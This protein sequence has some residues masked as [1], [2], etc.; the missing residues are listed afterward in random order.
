MFN[1]TPTADIIDGT[2]TD[3]YFERTINALNHAEKNPTVIADIT[4]SQFTQDEY[5]ILSGVNNAVKTLAEA[6]DEID[7]WALPEGCAFTGGPVMRIKGPY[8][9]FAKFET[10]ILGFLSHA[11]GIATNAH[12]IVTSAKQESETTV[13]SFGGRAKHPSIAPYIERSALIG[14]VD[15]ISHVS[16]ANELGVDATGT[17]PHALVLAFQS[18]EKAWNAYNESAEENASR[19]VIAD[20]FTDETDEALR[21]AE[22]LGDDLNGIR[23]DTTG[24]RRG[25]F[26]HIIREVK[27]KLKNKGFKDIP[28][29]IS[30][31]LTPNTVEQLAPL[32]SGVGV[33]GYISDADSMDFSLDIVVNE[34]E[35]ITK[36]GKLPG[37]KAPNIEQS[38]HAPEE[39]AGTYTL[40]PTD[41]P[42]AGLF[43]KVVNNGVVLRDFSINKARKTANKTTYQLQ[44]EH[45][46]VSITQL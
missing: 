4:A 44:D 27:Y 36:R 33:G 38:K 10:S 35:D 31:G 1:T 11:T 8:T 34:G 26:E 2:A 39:T 6:S 42:S 46:H 12:T 7:V 23:L 28:I 20:T 43:D 14:G 41:N 19:T 15:G 5:K 25:D 29:V 18:P 32:V 17:M 37:L 9:E 24:S 3:K 21:A 13:L 40:T 30:G 45:K 22:A 16:A